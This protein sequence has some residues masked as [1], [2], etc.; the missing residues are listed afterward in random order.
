MTAIP[1]ALG[2]ARIF[3]DHYQFVLCERPDY[4]LSD[5]ENWTL[6]QMP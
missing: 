5:E 2:A 1:S 6:A 4:A 3:A